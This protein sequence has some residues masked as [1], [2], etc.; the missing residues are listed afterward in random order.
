LGTGRA[1]AAAVAFR[2]DPAASDVGFGF[3]VAGILRQGRMPVEAATIAL[4]RADLEASSVDV[5]V[6]ARQA[7]TP[8]PFISKALRGPW[9]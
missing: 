9:G 8:V 4:D 6:D 7:T 1:R 2:L 3:R 5:S